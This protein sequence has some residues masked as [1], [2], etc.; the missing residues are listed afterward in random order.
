MSMR[1]VNAI[2]INGVMLTVLAGCSG[3]RVEPLSTALDE[4]AFRD[5]VRILSADDFQ[6]RKPGTPGEQKTVAYLVEQFTKLGLK[7]GN[8]ASFT[9]AVPLVELTAA[10]DSTLRIAGRGA[11]TSLLYGRDAVIW[12]HRVQPEVTVTNSELVFVGHGVVAPEYDWDDYAGVDMKGKTAVVLINDPGFF[13]HDPTLFKG[14]TM[15][16]Y[17]RWSYK[18]EEASR[19][20]AAAVLIV[21]DTAGA[22]YGWSVIQTGWT[23]PQL[24]RVTTDPNTGRPLV[25]GWVS[26]AS[27]KALFAQAGMN[28]EESINAAS[29]RGFKARPMGLQAAAHVQTS[30]RYSTSANVLAVLPGAE[31]PKEYV[32]YVAHWDH[33]GMTTEPSGTQIFHG[34]IDNATGVAALLTLAQSMSRMP[35][36]PARSIVFLCTTAEEAGLLGS[37]YYVE[38]PTYPL[39]NTAAVINIDAM[40]V[41]GPTRDVS[42]VGFG[43]SELENY[44]RNA[45]SL[46]GRE[47]RPEPNPEQ[48]EFF[49]SDHFSFAKAGVPALYAKAGIDDTERG[50]KWG[51]AQEDAY[52]EHRYHQPADIYSADWDL[53]G[54]MQDLALYLAVGERLAHDR[55]FPNWLPNSEF[56]A[57]RER[58]RPEDA[59]GRPIEP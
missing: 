3:H 16:Y 30:I 10:N 4:D 59:Q 39:R 29:H 32:F 14:R 42:V 27:A 48:G 22:G 11:D 21:H 57:I 31:R 51:Q 17:G 50:P 55:R 58:D 46:Q 41:G 20:G 19:H 12:T 24:D 25:E 15:T 40:H 35:Q 7:P 28:L 53:R 45:A 6:G 5:H 37:A 18:F 23:G 34:A 1:R 38:H 13:T 44:L 43:N 33:L 56:R 2:L 36:R 9:Q 26:A 52:L 49:R 47:L 54:T 8:G